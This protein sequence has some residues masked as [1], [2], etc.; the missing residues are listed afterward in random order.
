[1]TYQTS[2]RRITTADTLL[3]AIDGQAPIIDA[4][5]EMG[6]LEPGEMSRITQAA[7]G[8]AAFV[9]LRDR[10]RAERLI[11]K[12]PPPGTPCRPWRP[13][14]AVIAAIEASA[15]RRE[16]SKPRGSDGSD[17]GEA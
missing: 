14:P 8:V 16:L 3:A 12:R 9:R 1:M 7:P 10:W 6:L 11:V 15:R 13:S 2:E 5:H 17:P 4:L